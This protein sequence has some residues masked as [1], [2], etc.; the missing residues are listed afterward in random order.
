MGFI[1]NQ[2]LKTI[3]WL[4]DSKNILVYR[5]PMNGRKIMMGSK[6]TVRESQVAI[7]VNNGKVADVFE[8]GIH[9]LSTSNLPFLT[10]M[11]SW[12]YGFK[13]PFTSEIYFVSTKQF[14]NQKWGTSNPIA[15]RDPE[16][17]TIRIR[18]YG[19]YSFRVDEPSTFLKELFGSNST[20]QT[21]D[22]ANYLR[23]L[24]V[25]SVSDA[26]ASSKISAIDLA[27]N[28]EEFG[29]IVLTKGD[30]KLRSLG[31]KLVN[32]NIENL[33]FPEEIEKAIDTRASMGVLQDQ[34]D[35]FVKYQSASALRDAAKNNSGNM[36]TA[37]MQLGAGVA[38]SGMMADQLKSVKGSE[39][40]GK[41]DKITCP[42]CHSK[43]KSSA[44]FCPE[45]GSKI[46]VSF[47]KECGAK[48]APGAKFCSEC[49]TKLK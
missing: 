28:L 22:I 34:M 1:S 29:E 30:E 43:I 40:E 42:K 15:M 45:C 18:G 10:T 4:D 39:G 35:T 2:L 8:P 36:A 12:P 41:T 7:F 23:S 20:F 46:T 11:L 17:G 49:G 27:A 3:D 25:T 48:A 31:L 9:K 13:S 37:G 14:T 19:S 32:F 38:L 5:Y 33:S 6:L 47:C 16:F 24:I 44:K 26:I 21:E